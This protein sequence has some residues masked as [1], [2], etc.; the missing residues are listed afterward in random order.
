MHR[1]HRVHWVCAL[2]SQRNWQKQWKMIIV[3]SCMAFLLHIEFVYRRWQ[4]HSLSSSLLL[5]FYFY[6]NKF[7]NWFFSIDKF[8]G[9]F[10]FLFLIKTVVDIVDFHHDDNH[11]FREKRWF[12]ISRGILHDERFASLLLYTH[13]TLHFLRFIA[14]YLWH[15]MWVHN[16]QQHMKN[17]QD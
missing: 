1:V 14:K 3:A 6:F 17:M 12:Y 5:L 2:L 10:F 9:V 15:K 16:K 7:E 13:A 11:P 4:F 8:F